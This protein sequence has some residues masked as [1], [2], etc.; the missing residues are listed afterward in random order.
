MKNM[1]FAMDVLL[2][3]DQEDSILKSTQTKLNKLIAFSKYDA[4]AKNLG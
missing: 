4:W 3:S 2:K 1:N